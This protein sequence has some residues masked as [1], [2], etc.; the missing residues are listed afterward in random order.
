ML[1]IFVWLWVK[2]HF[3]I[4]ENCLCFWCEI[5]EKIKTLNNLFW[6]VLIRV[7]EVFKINW[8]IE[9]SAD[10]ENMSEVEAVF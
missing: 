9:Y 2:N 3:K 1:W 7:T 4:E 10:A 6:K 5:F 8:E